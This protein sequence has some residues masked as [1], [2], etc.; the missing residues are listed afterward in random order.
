MIEHK[1]ES[2]KI[3]K[4]TPAPFSDAKAVYQSLL[5]ELKTLKLDAQA[6]VDVN[7][8]K[9]LF[10]VALASEELEK[11]IWKCMER[12]IY[13]GHKIIPDTFED[14]K[15]R[16]DYLEVLLVVGKNNVEPFMKALMQKSSHLLEMM[17]KV[18]A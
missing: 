1:L 3:L 14:V 17:K 7:L 15:A 13:D 16:E 12:C 5:K 6:D 9:D 10:C 4:I 18:L 8:Y 11:A 2:G